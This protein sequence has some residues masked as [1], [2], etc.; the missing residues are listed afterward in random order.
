DAEA[1]GDLQ[2]AADLEE[3]AERIDQRD[4]LRMRR[5]DVRGQELLKRDPAKSAAAFSEAIALAKQQDSTYRAILYFKRG[6]AWRNAKDPR[7]DDDVAAAMKILRNEVRG[8]LAKDPEAASEPLWTPYFIR[9]REQ[10]NELIE[11]RI[12]AQ[13]FDGALVYAELSRAFE[14][15]Q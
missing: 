10:H 14:P 13:D 3:S 1:E 11:S 4:L 12:A 5:L 15:M 7:A 6:E 2:Q 8:A 9:F